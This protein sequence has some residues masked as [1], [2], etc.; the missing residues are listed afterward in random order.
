VSLHCVMAASRTFSGQRVRAVCCGLPGVEHIS[1]GD[2]DYEDLGVLDVGRQ[3]AR[4]LTASRGELRV[5]AS[6][7]A[8]TRD[9]VFTCFGPARQALKHFV[10][11]VA[12]VP[13]VSEVVLFQDAEGL[14]VWTIMSER[15]W[16]GETAI[17]RAHR[18]LRSEYEGGELDLLIL[19]CPREDAEDRLPAG[20]VRLYLREQD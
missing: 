1:I 9:T 15:K 4:V 3:A 19:A 2:P 10:D 16:D 13:E 20:F 6:L 11:V 14:H 8:L 12:R 5:S 18:A 17:L 7:L